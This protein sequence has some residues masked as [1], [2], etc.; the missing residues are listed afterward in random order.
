[1]S[2]YYKCEIEKD[3]Y[4]EDVETAEPAR[5]PYYAYVILV[6]LLIAFLIILIIFLI[7]YRNLDILYFVENPYINE[8]KPY[9]Y[10]A[11]F[12]VSAFALIIM[13]MVKISKNDGKYLSTPAI[14]VVML[15]FIFTLILSIVNMA[16]LSQPK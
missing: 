2:A 4:K 5:L 13:S 11:I 14:S 8:R 7:K 6:F 9:V 16:V 15:V 10:F 3:G 12:G 1:M